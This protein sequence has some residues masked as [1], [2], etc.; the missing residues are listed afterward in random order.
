[1]AKYVFV[2]LSNSVSDDVDDEILEPHPGPND[3]VFPPVWWPPR[4]EPEEPEP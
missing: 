3:E 1:M 2:V 4:P